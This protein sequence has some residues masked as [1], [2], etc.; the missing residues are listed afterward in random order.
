MSGERRIDGR[1]APGEEQEEISDDCVSERAAAVGSASQTGPAG[2]G[3]SALDYEGR[4]RMSAV[5]I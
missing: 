3:S 1:R 5:S 4:D 2:Q